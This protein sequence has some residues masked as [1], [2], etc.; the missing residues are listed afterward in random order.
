MISIWIITQLA[1][2]DYFDLMIK[3]EPNKNIFIWCSFKDGIDK[4][5]QNKFECD[6]SAYIS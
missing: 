6:V 5:Y 3:N 4:A 1:F 2:I